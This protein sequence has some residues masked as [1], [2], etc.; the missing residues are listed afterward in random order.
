MDVFSYEMLRVYKHPAVQD[1]LSF[2]SEW[3][4][5]QGMGE[6]CVNYKEFCDSRISTS[7]AAVTGAND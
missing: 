1:Y 7:K 4:I 6:S 3:Q 2:L 5:E